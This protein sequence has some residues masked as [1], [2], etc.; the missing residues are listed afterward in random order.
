MAERQ[1]ITDVADLDRIAYMCPHCKTVIEFSMKEPA[2]E[3]GKID[4]ICCPLSCGEP[5]RLTR[6]KEVLERR[7]P[8]IQHEVIVHP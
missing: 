4:G 8:F 1:I 3:I 7:V 2:T 5:R 6:F